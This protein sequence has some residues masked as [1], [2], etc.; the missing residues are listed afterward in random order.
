[1]NPAARYLSIVVCLF[2]SGAAGPVFAGGKASPGRL[3]VGAPITIDAEGRA[4]VGRL[5]GAK[6]PLAEVAR[7]QLSEASY[8]PA[9]KDGEPVASRMYASAAIVLTLLS[10][11]DY[12][13]KVENIAVAPV[14]RIASPPLYPIESARRGQSGYVTL[15]LTVGADG[16]VIRAVTVDA[17]NALFSKAV[18]A[19]TSR[20]RFESSSVD[21]SNFE[22]DATLPVWFQGNKSDKPPTFVCRW[23]E[24]RPRWKHQVEGG[25][26]DALIITSR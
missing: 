14:L 11:G 2:A 9:S 18:L 22:Y 3:W 13:V 20:W 16:R 4:S 21:A 17:T 23:D 7:A 15:E 25:C 5:V 26:L 6:G 24:R 1:M 8:V 10:G 19:V 12:A